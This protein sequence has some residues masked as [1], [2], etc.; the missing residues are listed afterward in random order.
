MH[1]AQTAARAARL[2]S[3]GAL[4][5]CTA[6]SGAAR[7]ADQPP[8]IVLVLAD[9]VGWAELGSHG[10][11]FNETPNLDRMA[12]EGVRFTAAYSAGPVCS[13]T[14]AA[15]MT[16][17]WPARVG[18]IDYLR[19]RDPRFL[20]P[21]RYVALP[22]A[23]GRLGYATGLVGKWHLMGNY[24]LRRGD[25]KLH[26]FDEVILSES[27]YVGRADY[28]HPYAFMPAVRA[29]QPGEYLVDRMNREAV[30]FIRRHHARAPEQ[31][32]FLE[33]SHYAVH[34]DLVGR[35]DL[36]AKYARKPGAGAGPEARHH[37]PHLAAQL[38]SVDGGVG[39]ILSTLRELGI[40]GRTLVIFTS[41]NGGAL[42]VTTNA[43]LRGGKA[44]L[45][46]GGIRVPLIVRGPG[47]RRGLVTDA[48]A[49]STD[50]YATLLEVAGRPD[51]V[52]P[53]DGMSLTPVLRG[54]PAAAR[55]PLFWHYPLNQALF[56]DRPS[57]SAIRSGRMKLIDFFERDSL[58]LYDVASDPGERRNLAAA[59]PAQARQLRAQLAAW[60]RALRTDT[61]TLP[62]R[63]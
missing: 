27:T 24:M 28:V 1:A 37:N 35:P 60:R 4:A 58:E 11:R 38:E 36:V 43:P 25:P 52:R 20:D 51:A 59:D 23:L 17:L 21:A 53:L 9:D 7:P 15:L 45:Y 5:A 12:R 29:R 6:G 16:G 22:K 34:A 19:P 2:L 42:R 46:E 57:A 63:R 48:L 10:N 31:P 55:G 50:L 56:P 8:N 61:L 47:V 49:S 14:R 41:D 32:F 30:D 54:R 39:M 44:T 13:P 3:L 33:L 26:G 62:V 40:G 18:I